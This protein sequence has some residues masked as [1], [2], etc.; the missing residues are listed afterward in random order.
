MSDERF[1]DEEVRADHFKRIDTELD[2]K[3]DRVQ[4]AAVPGGNVIGHWVC[5]GGCGAA[6]DV[7]EAA[8]E[9]MATFNGQLRRRG[10]RPLDTSRIV[11]CDDCRKVDEKRYQERAEA[12][13]GEIR[14]R[15]DELRNAGGPNPAREE[16]L[17]REL[18]DLGCND[19]GAI[20]HAIKEKRRAGSG[21]RP[22][23]KDVLR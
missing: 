3:R 18:R 7:T 23:S 11:F 5:R 8:F 19:I 14:W 2:F 1:T 17:V 21:D 15:I 9:A 20:L 22:R 13:R 4:R 10:E 16:V 6:V 12:A